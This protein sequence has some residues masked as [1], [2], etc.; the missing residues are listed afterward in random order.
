MSDDKTVVEKTIVEKT[1]VEAPKKRTAVPASAPKPAA[2][3]LAADATVAAG[4]K[5]VARPA[6]SRPAVSKPAAGAKTSLT[7]TVATA[8]KGSAAAAILKSASSTRTSVSRGRGTPA[9]IGKYP[10]KKKLAEGGMGAVFIGTHPQ[11]KR[12]VILKKLKLKTS[13]NSV[14]LER[15]KRE[16]EIMMNLQCPYIVNTFDYFDEGTSHYI[17]E[18]FVEGISLSE[19]I[20]KQ[21][22]LGTEMSALIFL[23]A[24]RALQFAHNRKIVHRDIKPANILISK[25]AEVK[26]ADFGIAGSDKELNDSS[27]EGEEEI[28]VKDIQADDSADGITKSGSVLGTPAYM[29]P[30]QL[31]DASSVDQRADI[32]SMGVMF[33]EMLTGSKPFDS[34]LKRDGSLNEAAYE[35]I[36]KG[37]Y[38][39]PRRLDKSIPGEFCK[40]IKKMLRFDRTERFE[41]IDDVIAI[42]KHYLSRYDAHAIRQNLARAICEPGQVEIPVFERKKQVLLTVCLSVIGTAILVIGS[43]AMWKSGFVHK[44]FLSPWYRPVIVNVELP[45]TKIG[46]NLY[47]T[48]L[49][50]MAYFFEDGGD[51]D[52]V[53]GRSRVFTLVKDKKTAD[54]QDGSEEESEVQEVE[55]NPDTLLYTI[56][57]AYLKDG[58]YRVK[59]VLGSYVWWQSFKVEEESVTLDVS[60]AVSNKRSVSIRAR[61]FDAETGEDMTKSSSFK[62]MYGGKWVNL[63]NVSPK[64][65]KS[66]AVH[67]VKVSAKGY[68]ETEFSM[69]VDW[70]QDEVFV[71]A[72]L[73]KEVSEDGSEK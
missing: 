62:I 18:E 33:Y 21:V 48:N 24:C 59:V 72:A 46:N 14:V 23:D 40:M 2:K 3:T 65:L 50:V 5:R 38:V 11:L 6:A 39:N 47:N 25:R 20:E 32:F 7:S 54:S 42:L 71:N 56:R 22:S 13:K 69:I 67:K 51:Q 68:R 53:K 73:Q 27:A 1:V 57:P 61:A 49:P 58:M 43:V 31:A 34:P 70:Y 41:K 64:N 26:L 55:E 12:D 15:F 37:K 28:D 8:Q 44:T 29:S 9:F 66:G 63:Y 17:V 60:L 30:E 4:A 10:I 35:K 16:A 52:E 36:K 45:N 19:L